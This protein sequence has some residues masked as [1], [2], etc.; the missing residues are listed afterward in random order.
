MRS[1]IMGAASA[2]LLASAAAAADFK[3]QFASGA[4]KVLNGRG[5]LQ[6]FDLTTDKTRMRVIAPGSRITERG[7]VRVL[8]LNLGQP[9]Y[10][11]GPDQV[12]VELPD[13][14]PLSEV[15]VAIFDTKEA[16]LQKLVNING[17]VDRNVK[18]N[19]SA[20]AQQANSG[21]T[22]AT[23]SGGSSMPDSAGSNALK[24]DD[25]SESAPG[26]KVLGGLNGILR[27]L[28][29]GPKEA[30]GGYLVF[31]MPKALHKAKADQPVTIVVRTGREVH[32]IRAVLNRV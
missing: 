18:A 5:G 17:A 13:G 8:V 1:M 14:T 10:E 24:L 21:M 7:A 32:R 23:I 20:Y 3:L 25:I 30:W 16:Q 26:A 29:V 27:P 22:A 4:G 6:V 28:A 2:I 12:S 31:N 15:P 9:A 19:L 11:F